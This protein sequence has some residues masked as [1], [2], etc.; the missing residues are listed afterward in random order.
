MVGSL[1]P[2]V[3][4]FARKACTAVSMI[5]GAS[6]TFEMEASILAEWVAASGSGE[7]ETATLEHFWPGSSDS[8]VSAFEQISINRAILALAFAAS[9]VARDFLRIR[10][11]FK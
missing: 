11:P 3:S 2:F 10:Y 6:C 8:P 5:A 7:T 1:T 4:Q 9:R